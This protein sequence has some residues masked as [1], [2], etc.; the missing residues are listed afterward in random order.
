MLSYIIRR[1]LYAVPILAGVMFI[2]FVIFFVVQPPRARARVVLGEKANEQQ[3]AHW[4]HE[5]GYDKDRF[6]NTSNKDRPFYDSLFLSQMSKLVSFSFGLSDKTN[7][8]I[9]KTFAEGVVPTLC[10]TVPA[11]IMGLIMAVSL[12]LYQVFVRYSAVDRFGILLCVALMSLPPMVYMFIGQS[13]LAMHFNYFPAFGFQLSGF[14]T[15][16]FIA[17]P[18]LLMV[19]MYLG[20]DVRIYRTVFLEE[21]TQDY[22]RTALAK[23]VPEIRLLFVHVLKNGMISLITLVVAH[24]P[25]LIMGSMLVENFFGIPG[26]GNTMVQAIQDGDAAMANAIVY[27][28]ALLFLAALLLTDILYAVADPRIRLS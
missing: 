10:L 8:P 9:G 20:Y 28:G 22:V 1:L 3:I 4:L 25:F 6:I 21:I 7:R 2:T 17:L 16:K 14:T 23:G 27:L 24:L 13:V 11:F 5:K 12:S 15:F 18:S 19:I 26:L